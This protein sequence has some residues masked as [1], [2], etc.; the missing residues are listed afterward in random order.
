MEY[1]AAIKTHVHPKKC[2]IT[3]ET[4]YVTGSVKKRTITIVENYTEKVL[5][6]TLGI[7]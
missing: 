7:S 3:W 4:A 2:A 5:E 1:Y 6:R